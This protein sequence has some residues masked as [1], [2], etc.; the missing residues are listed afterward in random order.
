M[1]N[2]FKFTEKAYKEFLKLPNNI[3][4]RIK[5]KLSQLKNIEDLGPYL[6]KIHGIENVPY[7]IRIGSY[8]LFP[9]LIDKSD[10]ARTFLVTKVA[11]RKDMYKT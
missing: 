1:K 7:R 9:L 11:H 5:T 6:K 4:I 10:R 8:R 3:Q 2:T